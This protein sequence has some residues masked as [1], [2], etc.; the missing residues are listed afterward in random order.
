MEQ[1]FEFI[2][3]HPI[4]VVAWLG[5]LSA[6]IYSLISAKLGGYSVFNTHEATMLINREDA[7]VLDTRAQDVFRKGHIAGARNI[8]ASKIEEKQISE[9]E[10]YQQ[11]PIIV[12]DDS[13]LTSSKTCSQ[14]HKQG[15]EKVGYL[16]GGMGEWRQ[17]G[18]PVA[19]K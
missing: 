7:V 17:A 6:L 8:S 16:R 3:N 2:G 10:K 19:K 11:H 18:L 4:L 9:L 13:G 15:F 14:L 5:L 1:I 12:V